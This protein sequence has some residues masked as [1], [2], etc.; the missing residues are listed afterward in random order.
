MSV[1]EKLDAAIREKV[2]QRAIL[3]QDIKELRSVRK[4]V[5]GNKRVALVL[6][7]VEKLEVNDVV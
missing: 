3:L 5:E 4:S 7:T 6:D 2:T 1:M